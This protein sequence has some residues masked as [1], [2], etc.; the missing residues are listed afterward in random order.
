MKIALI[1]DHQIVSE[2]LK[3][4]L[5]QSLPAIESI[6]HHSSFET[7]TAAAGDSVPTIVITELSFNGKY[8]KGIDAIFR[9]NQKNI[10]IIILT[11]LS[12]DWL[13]RSYMRLGA[14]AFL[15]KTCLYNELLEA[16]AQVQKGNLFLS[17]DV[18]NIL[19][20]GIMTGRASVESLSSIERSIMEAL[21]RDEPFKLIANKLKISVI[22]LKYHRKM[23][24]TRFNVKNFA[25]LIELAQKPG[26]LK[27]EAAGS[28]SN[29]EHS[30]WKSSSK[31]RQ[32][33][34]AMSV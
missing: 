4:N 25:D 6:E 18:Q 8:D 30:V 15:T 33:E 2:A 11:S 28:K 20:T 9:L 27:A 22:E 16:I 31:L 26:F 19:L 12:D 14:K 32:K 5:M 3:V 29:I 10:K 34:T 1:D 21:A 17:E 24:M 13:V 23:L 7:F